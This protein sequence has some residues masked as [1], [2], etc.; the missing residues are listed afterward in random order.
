M[1]ESQYR[2][3][4]KRYQLPRT[5]GELERRNRMS[6][7]L[8][9]QNYLFI[10][11]ALPEY[12]TAGGVISTLYD[13][14][15]D[16]NAVSIMNTKKSEYEAFLAALTDA[17]AVRYAENEIAGNLFKVDLLKVADGTE[18]AVYTSYYP[19]NCNARIVFGPRAFLPVR[20]DTLF[21]SGNGTRTSVV[22]IGRDTVYRVAPGM[23]Y[24]VT[25]SDGSFLLIDGGPRDAKVTPKALDGDGNWI[26]TEPKDTNDCDSLYEYLRS[27]TPTGQKPVIA[28]WFFSHY[29]SDHVDLACDFL[30]K[31]KN[32]VE[33]RIGAYNFPDPLKYPTKNENNEHLARCKDTITARLSEAGATPWIFH[34]GE[35]MSFPGCEAEI[36]YTHEEYFPKSYAWGNHTSSAFRLKFS[37]KTFMVLGDCEKDICQ[38][39]ADKYGTVLKSDLLELSHHGVNGA[40][41]AL[42]RLID[43]DDCFWAIDDYRFATDPRCLGT[44]HDFE[45]NAFLRNDEIKARRHYHSSVTSVVY[46]DGSY[47]EK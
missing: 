47:G 6:T 41:V 10:T 16:N 32:D 3:D 26:D 44:K 11:E 37:E 8:Q 40:C 21:S 39:M 18:Y 13:C 4:T 7:S 17:G 30:A 45:F 24:V 22:Q 28:A 9:N 25:L 36:L 31:Y 46:T 15:N 29:H 35:T 2:F 5:L 1:T 12:R 23:S 38:S 33:V 42:Y 20:D 34:T 27:R 14:G 43:P 19:V